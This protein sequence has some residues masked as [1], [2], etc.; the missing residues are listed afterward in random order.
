[1][2]IKYVSTDTTALFEAATG[3][4]KKMDLL[5]G[6]RVD[7]VTPGATRSAVKAHANTAF[8]Q[9]AAPGDTPLLEVYFI[10]G[11]Q[12]DGILIRTPDGRHVMIDGG[13]KRAMQ[14]TGK[15]AG[16]FVDWKF[17]KDYG[18]PQIHLDA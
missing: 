6:D 1:M 14:P 17:A 4:Q 7:V 3:T 11:G 9:N 5:W 16:D 2:A 15:N 12:G 13:Y 8:C 10:D 18:L